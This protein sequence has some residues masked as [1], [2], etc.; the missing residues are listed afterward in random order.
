MYLDILL[1]RMPR[2]HAIDIE[3]EKTSARNAS[4]S[5]TN[6]PTTIVNATSLALKV[7]YI[8]YVVYAEYI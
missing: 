7:E 5:A 3:R 8:V 6:A 2:A 1:F 4:L